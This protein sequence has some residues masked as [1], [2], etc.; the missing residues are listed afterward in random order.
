MTRPTTEQIAHLTHAELSA[1][2]K[3]LIVAVQRLEAENR[4]LKA[5]VAKERPSHCCKGH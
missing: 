3:E 5:E 2:V 1:L 4:Q